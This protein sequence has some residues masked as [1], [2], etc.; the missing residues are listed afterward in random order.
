LNIRLLLLLLEMKKLLKRRYGRNTH[1][2][3]AE[4]RR[5]GIGQ[6]GM[7]TRKEP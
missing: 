5:L 3:A 1:L 7:T 2:V 6:C 4:Y